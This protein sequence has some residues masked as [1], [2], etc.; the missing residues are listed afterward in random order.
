MAE[1]REIDVD[2]PTEPG[3]WGGPGGDERPPHPSRMDEIITLI[4]HPEGTD[5][6][7]INR[8]I[9]MEIAYALTDP[10][11]EFNPRAVNERVKSLRELSKTLQEGDN[12]S[13]KDFLNFDGPK[14]KYVLQEVVMLFRGSLKSAGHK[15]DAINHVLRVFRDQL[16]ARETELRRETERVTHESVFMTS[17][18][19]TPELSPEAEA[20]ST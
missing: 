14:F 1:D 10:K 4:D 8:L 16:S 3:V 11:I 5:L 9:A 2:K 7:G 6:E 13:K 15:E 18:P 17:I 12:L 20:P 19:T